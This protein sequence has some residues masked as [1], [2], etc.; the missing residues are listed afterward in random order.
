ME[1]QK[2][3]LRKS[4]KPVT[5]ANFNFKNLQRRASEITGA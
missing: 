1:E 3:Q 4:M 5:S 2:R